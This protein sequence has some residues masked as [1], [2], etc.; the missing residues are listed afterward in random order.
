LRIT[1]LTVPD[2][3]IKNIYVIIARER[4]NKW[5]NIEDSE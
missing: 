4:I 1:K 3:R 5:I 2:E